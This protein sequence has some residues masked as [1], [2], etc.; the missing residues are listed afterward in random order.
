MLASASPRRLQLLERVG[1]RPDLLNPS[2]IDE[3]PHK[4]ET[5]RV[6]RVAVSIALACSK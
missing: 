4:R 1:L 3:I 5:P 2:D 6:A